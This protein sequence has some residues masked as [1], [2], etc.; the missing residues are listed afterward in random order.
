MSAPTLPLSERLAYTVAEAAH[1]M[2]LSEPVLRA[3][4]RRGEIPA[5]RCGQEAGRGDLRVGKLAIERFL[6]QKEEAP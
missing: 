1:L 4:I 3:M 2:G 6:L 5:R